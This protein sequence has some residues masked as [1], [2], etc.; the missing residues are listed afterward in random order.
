[1]VSHNLKYNAYVYNQLSALTDT[2]NGDYK[3]EYLYEKIPDN[4][5]LFMVPK[6]SSLPT[7]IPN[8]TDGE[9][10]S[11]TYVD[12]NKLTIRYL[13]GTRTD[14]HGNKRGVYNSKVYKIYVEAPEG[15]MRLAGEGDIIANRLAIF[16]FIKGD[17]DSVILTNSPIYNSVSLSNLTVTNK[18]TFY[19]RPVILDP[20]TKDEIPLA[21]NTDLL[22]LTKRVEKLEN[23]FQYG[24]EDAENALIDA[25]VGTIYIQVE[26]GE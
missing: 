3:I 6:Y 24:T 26:E 9:E 25:D 15:S 2:W 4:S 21:T 22:S 19:S 14:E 23:K 11:T 1:M 5:L 13:I 12:S 10:Y 7:G 17:K 20:I 16:R 18:A 8:D